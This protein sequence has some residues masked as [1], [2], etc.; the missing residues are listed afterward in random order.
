MEILRNVHVLLKFGVLSR[1]LSGGN[2]VKR[3]KPQ[4]RM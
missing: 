2:E 4:S 1:Y 3:E